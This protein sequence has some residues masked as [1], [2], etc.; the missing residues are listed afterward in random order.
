MKKQ[1]RNFARLFIS[2]FCL[3]IFS[4]A[5][6]YE[7]LEQN[8][9]QAAQTVQQTQSAQYRQQPAPLAVHQVRSN[10]YEV[11]GGSGANT[12]FYV[13]ASGVIV[14]D[15][16]MSDESARQMVNEI[17]KI[18]PNPIEYIIIT[19]SDGD[20]VNGLPGFPKGLKII[21]H[22]NARK[23][24]DEAF[25][26]ERQRAF[27]P[28]IT[29]SEKLILFPGDKKVKLLHFGPAHTNGDT[30]VYF[31]DDKVAFLGDLLFIGRDPLIHRHKNGNSFGSVKT[32]KAVLEL[33]AEIFLHGHGDAAGKAEIEGMIKMLEEKQAKI[34]SLIEE[35]KSLEEIKKIFNIEDRPAQAGTMPRPSLVEVIYLEL[36]DK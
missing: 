30:V 9:G 31:P 21:A 12:G 1:I 34:K 7:T 22:N 24:M 33:D 11:K 35:G 17:Q 3:F 26:E 8:A 32:L 28:N 25:K 15:A 4:G 5:A 10:I 19:H 6:E 27:L 18:T 29:Y 13:G 2:L 20:H 16:K 36:T 14:I 23:D